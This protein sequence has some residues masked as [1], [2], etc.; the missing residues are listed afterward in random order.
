MTSL[1]CAFSLTAFHHGPDLAEKEIEDVGRATGAGEVY[2]DFISNLNRISQLTG[3]LRLCSSVLRLM[4]CFTSGF[5]D[6]IYA[7]AYV[8]VHGFDIMLGTISLI[9]LFYSYGRLHLDVLLV[10]Q[11]A[12]TLQSL[13]LDFATLGDLKLV[14]RPSVYTIAPHNVQSIKATIKVGLRATVMISS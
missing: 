2:E 6:P 10:N 11:T 3:R 8:K 5:S 14:E 13:C 7:E 9:F 4:R 1:M 12:D